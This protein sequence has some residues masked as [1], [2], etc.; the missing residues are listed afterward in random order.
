M[1]T[2]FYS[3]NIIPEE[4]TVKNS[5]GIE[6][7]T[8]FQNEGFEKFYKQQ[9]VCSDEEFPDLMASCRTGL[10]SVFRVIKNKPNYQLIIDKLK[11]GYL[12]SIGGE[13]MPW[14][15]EDLVWRLDNTRWDLV[16]SKNMDIK[17]LH[18][19][20]VDQDRLGNIY[21]QEQVS[22]V[23]VR[24]LDIQPNHVV[25][26]M[27]ASP[28][29]KTG[30][31]LEALHGQGDGLPTG[32]VIAC[33]PNLK[34]CNNLYGNMIDFRSPCLMVVN[35][36]GQAFPDL[37]WSNGDQVQ[38]DHIVCD[39]PCSGDGTI[40]KNP[41]IWANWH[42]A[43]G[44]G[45][46]NLQLNIARRGVELLKE[47]G[48]MAYSSC[49]INQ[50]EN[51]AVIAQLLREAKGSLEL[52]EM[53]GK[54]PGLNWLPGLSTW[55]VFDNNMQEYSSMSNVPEN[56][57][58]QIR[59][60]MFPPSETEVENFNLDKCM[61]FLPHLNNDGG[62]FVAILKKTG[63]I[64]PTPIHK[65]RRER[66]NT[67]KRMPDRRYRG[68]MKEFIGSLDGFEFAAEDPN[69]SEEVKKSLKFIDVDLPEQNLYKSKDCKNNV[70]L[71]SESLR[72]LMHK[73]N[74]HLQVG[75]NPG[76][77]FMRRTNMKT[78]S[79]VPFHTSNSSF[80]R[81][82]SNLGSKRQISAEFSDIKL[83][84]NSDVVKVDQLSNNLKTQVSS[85]ETGWVLFSYKS[86]LTNGVTLS[87][88]GYLS[89]K[90]L[91]IQLSEKEKTHYKFLLD[92]D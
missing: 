61:R 69:Y 56:L 60:E 46:F 28:G 71:V 57:L 35:H 44:N 2:A 30:Q 37:S 21:R 25:L 43:R 17:K 45:R 59:S 55:K 12:S 40:R 62:F 20:I 90:K 22:M 11:S 19:W 49:S 83:L 41:N 23:P 63:Y 29:S 3:T 34:R 58:T 75:G 52:V 4:K 80:H 79:S 50:I 87:C 42:P 88:P 8:N 15:G 6:F 89:K 47:G 1:S 66:K 7:T 72:N 84:L 82:S 53:S 36:H 86:Y 81:L 91:L 10:P 92:I 76:V 54:F 39:V 24:C 70:R 68:R 5:H 14:Y 33:E 64:E 32:C 67:E 78:K 9:A 26:D 74:E 27:C 51:E 85:L 77:R 65:E 73:E 48:T 13:V 31:V 16:D 38:Y 18:R